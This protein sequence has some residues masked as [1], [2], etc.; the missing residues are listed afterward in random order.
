MMKIYIRIDDCVRKM[1]KVKKI[2]GENVNKC[3]IKCL[4][5]LLVTIKLN[6]FKSYVNL[7]T[8]HYIIIF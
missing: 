4:C 8:Y 1:C 7:N 3:S 2:N 6:I 5:F